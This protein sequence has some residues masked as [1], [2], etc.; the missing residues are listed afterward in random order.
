[1]HIQ[2]TSALGLK[3]EVFVILQRIDYT[4]LLLFGWLSETPTKL[5]TQQQLAII[6]CKLFAATLKCNLNGDERVYI[7]WDLWP[8]AVEIVG[9]CQREV[10]QR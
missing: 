9:C 7:M 8:V 10:T 1:M 2:S 4:T 6:R 3:A 5:R